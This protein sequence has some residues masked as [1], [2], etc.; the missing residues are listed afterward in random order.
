VDSEVQDLIGAA[1]DALFG[2]ATVDWV[3]SYPVFSASIADL[4]RA[5]KPGVMIRDVGSSV[6][7]QAAAPVPVRSSPSVAPVATLSPL[8]T[9]PAAAALPLPASRTPSPASDP[10]PPVPGNSAVTVPSPVGP[11][12]EED[13]SSDEATV[14]PLAAVRGLKN[15]KPYEVLDYRPPN[16]CLR[17]KKRRKGCRFMVGTDPSTSFCALCLHEGAECVWPTPVAA[18]PAGEISSGFLGFLFVDH[19]LSQLLVLVVPS[20]QLLLVRRRLRLSSVLRPTTIFRFRSSPTFR[21]TVLLLWVSATLSLA[22]T[23]VCG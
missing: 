5:L 17:C 14:R 7:S 12:P 23:L 1:H 10:S 2:F 20:D 9:S 6:A 22:V 21:T 3:Q 11:S 15:K 4:L 16:P 19:R 8:G 13:S 18:A